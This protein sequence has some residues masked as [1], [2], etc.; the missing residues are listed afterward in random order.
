M[1]AKAGVNPGFDVRAVTAMLSAPFNALKPVIGNIN[2]SI[3]SIRAKTQGL[4]GGIASIVE[5]ANPAAFQ[6][7]SFAV[8]DTLAVLGQSLTPVLEAAT[9]LIR[10]FGDILATMQPVLDPLMQSVADIIGMVA[11]L[12]VPAAQVVT[13]LIGLMAQALQKIK[14]ILEGVVEAV[15]WM[16]KATV[17]VIN[18]M[19]EAIN[20][21][22]RN[23]PGVPDKWQLSPLSLPDFD[24]LPKR[25]SVGAAVR[26]ASHT[27]AEDFGRKARATAFSQGLG[28]GMTAAEEKQISLLEM[29]LKEAQAQS[30]HLKFLSEIERINKQKYGG[31]SKGMATADAIAN[32]SLAWAFSMARLGR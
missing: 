9:G 21:I 23:T 12:L 16:A 11:Q 3:D 18:K 13:P 32:S 7:F 19:I 27:S 14:P 8:N 17:I 22:I 15:K 24:S 6:Q 5:M 30:L 31:Q 1:A 20:F 2:T 29:L 10:K 26:M 25:S 4:F 28:K